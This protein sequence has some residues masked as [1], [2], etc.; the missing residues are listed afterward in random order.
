MFVLTS[1]W[2][3]SFSLLSVVVTPVPNIYGDLS[4]G[5]AW[6]ALDHVLVSADVVEAAGPDLTEGEEREEEGETYSSR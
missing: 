3:I 6:F 4:P 1:W 2:R 5:E